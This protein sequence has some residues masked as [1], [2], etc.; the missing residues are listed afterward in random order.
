MINYRIPLCSWSSDTGSIE[1][2]FVHETENRTQVTRPAIPRPANKL[3]KQKPQEPTT[4]KPYKSPENKRTKKKPLR[5]KA[6][7][8]KKS[9]QEKGGQLA[10]RR[11]SLLTIRI[12][13]FQRGNTSCSEE[14][15]DQEQTVSKP[16]SDM[17]QEPSLELEAF[18]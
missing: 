11:N 14:R 8:N 5:P 6:N 12:F 13:C 9:D 3:D 17:G 16:K 1:L 10:L 4:T 7:T 2:P 18:T 15:S